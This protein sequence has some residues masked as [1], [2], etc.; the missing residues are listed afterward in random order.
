MNTECC[1]HCKFCTYSRGDGMRCY[2]W[3]KPVKIGE[4]CDL[5]TKK[6]N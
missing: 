2:F 1:E 3:N 5:L 6:N 4:K